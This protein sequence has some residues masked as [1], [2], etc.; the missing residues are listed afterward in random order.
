MKFKRWIR[1]KNGIVCPVALARGKGKAISG[2]NSGRWQEIPGE[3][4]RQALHGAERQRVGCRLRL[5]KPL[6]NDR[7]Q[8]SQGGGA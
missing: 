3:P 8:R 7:A 2:E 6:E 4:G 5:R 1:L